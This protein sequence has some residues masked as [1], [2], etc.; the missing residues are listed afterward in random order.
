MN[1][2]PQAVLI[3]DRQ[4]RVMLRNHSA[5]KLLPEGDDVVTVLRSPSGV[6]IDWQ[7]DLAS[8]A[9]DPFG[10]TSRNVSL[11]GRGSR[12]LL[13]DVYLRHLGPGPGAPGIASAGGAAQGGVL[14][15]VEDVSQRASMERRLAAS[16]RLAAVGKVAAKVAHELNN[17]LDGVLRYIGLAQ[18]GASQETAKYLANAR[19]GLMRM[20]TI[21]RDLLDQSGGRKAGAER[22]TVE[23]LLEEALG[24]FSAR[25]QSLGVA[26]VCDL[27]DTDGLLTEGNIFQVFCNVIK[28]ALDAMPGGGMLNVRVRRAD[29]HHC[30]VQLADTGCGLT[31]EEVT[32]V[33]EPF[34]TTKPPGEGT[35]LGLSICREIV[36]AAGGTITVAPRPEGGAVVT[37]SLPVQETS[38]LARQR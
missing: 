20:V 19:G 32:K 15:V 30:V 10:L 33:F 24:A 23:K 5:Q 34:Y 37:L 31:E 22:G 35:G 1:S 26:V 16:E 6:P 18:R 11:A 7:A 17:P 36:T 28:N 27:A 13:V 38:S 3:V 21:I 12:Q 9:E 8:L 4:G 29:E 25:A 2:L 14:I